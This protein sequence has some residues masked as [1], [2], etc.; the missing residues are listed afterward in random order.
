MLFGDKLVKLSNR[1]NLS[2]RNA[3][4]MFSDILL[5]LDLITVL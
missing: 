2:K 3:V 4:K 5:Y 1:S